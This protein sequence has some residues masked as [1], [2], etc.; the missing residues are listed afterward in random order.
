MAQKGNV[1]HLRYLLLSALFI[2]TAVN[3]ADRA[4]IS[5]AGPAIARDL[6]LN[7]VTL[8]YVFS[9]FSWAYVFCQLPG[10]WL[11]DRFG[12]K[13]VYLTCLFAWSC[14]T[15]MLG[16]VWML[17]SLAVAA[18][19][20]LRMLVGAAESPCFPANS[21]IVSA[22]FPSAERG[23]ASALF[24]SAQYMG[25]VLFAPLMGWITHRY[26]WHWVFVVVGCLVFVLAIAAS[27]MLYSPRDH[28]RL[29]KA[30]LEYIEAGGAIVDM[31]HAEA[32]AKPQF[33]TFRQLVTNR[34]L[35]GVYLGQYGL[36][37]V[38]YF[39]L[40]WFPVYLVQARGMSILKVGFVASIPAL[41]GFVGNVSSGIIS[42]HLLKR[43]HSLTFAR[44]LPIV[45]GMTMST[46]MVACNYLRNEWAVVA[47][48]ALAFFG[49][50]FGALG[51]AVISDTAP[52]NAVGLAGGMFN[53]LG[54]IS[55]ITT[56]ISIGYHPCPK[57]LLAA[58]LWTGEAPGSLTVAAGNSP[59]KP[60][61]SH[62]D[63]CL[64]HLPPNVGFQSVLDRI[65]T[66]TET[67][68]GAD[69]GPCSK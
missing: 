58:A 16:G 59:G 57:Q 17:G 24:N 2:V 41:G 67:S 26:G 43:G 45:L 34:M 9:A 52:R 30:E 62:F 10:G 39:F 40:T 8:G 12:S 61:N 5:I 47:V 6:R 13:R 64:K 37:A 38:T 3:Y 11:L 66:T 20:A 51:W 14:V 28:P 32:K 27:R 63:Y 7:A 69:R 25:T 44:K 56:P 65:V 50:G 21:R 55:G 23:T 54:S 49:K 18:L 31:D 22:W 36:N 53:F 29:G 15:T 42:D 35:L 48:M 68:S 19:F 4:S 60:V 33:S 1:G 46:A